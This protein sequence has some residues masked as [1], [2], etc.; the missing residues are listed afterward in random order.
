MHKENLKLE[1]DGPRRIIVPSFL[2]L[3]DF[4]ALK[5][6]SNP[7]SS[8]FLKRGNPSPPFGK[9][10]RGRILQD[11]F[12]P[13]NCYQ[14]L[15]IEIY[16]RFGAWWLAIYRSPISIRIFFNSSLASGLIP[17]TGA[18]PAP[19]SIPMRLS[20][21]LITTGKVPN[22]KARRSGASRN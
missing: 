11:Y 5:K 15:V 7:P 9:G 1:R 10:R 14:L 6:T 19:A 20:A 16:L 4:S 13:L 2:V 12:K 17:P 8:L 22:S 18:I 21:S 3:Y